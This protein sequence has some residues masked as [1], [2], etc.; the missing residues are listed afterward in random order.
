MLLVRVRMSNPLQNISR[1]TISTQYNNTVYRAGGGLNLPDVVVSNQNPTQTQNTVVMANL[2]D[3]RRVVPVLENNDEMAAIPNFSGKKT[4]NVALFTKERQCEQLHSPYQCNSNQ[5][6]NWCPYFKT[7]VS[8]EVFQYGNNQAM[9]KQSSDPG[10]HI[11]G[12]V[13]FT[14]TQPIQLQLP[15]Q[16]QYLPPKNLKP[17]INLEILTGDGALEILGE[18]EGEMLDEEDLELIDEKI[19][20]D[21][22]Y[23]FLYYSPNPQRIFI[24][25]GS[26][27]THI[28]QKITTKVY[29][30]NR[31]ISNDVKEYTYDSLD[32]LTGMPEST[33]GFASF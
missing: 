9:C 24:P 6:C 8:D 3:G 21:S 22:A 5:D 19:L 23:D 15:K 28:D 27:D 31:V 16:K 7:C 10:L 1:P 32:N 12:P 13:K 20:D 29:E 17:D 14:L 26:R 25:D 18:E 11:N 4:D 33:L 2:Q 30:T